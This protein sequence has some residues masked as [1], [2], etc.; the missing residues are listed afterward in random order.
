MKDDFL[1]SVYKRIEI[2]VV[3]RLLEKDQDNDTLL[4]SIGW[5][6]Q[7]IDEKNSKIEERNVENKKLRDQIKN[8][9]LNFE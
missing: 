2:L 1:L 5:L 8:V 4:G 9:N 3:G 6:K 7:Q